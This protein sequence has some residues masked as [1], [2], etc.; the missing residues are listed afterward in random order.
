MS[1]LQSPVQHSGFCL[2]GFG[3]DELIGL[4]SSAPRRPRYFFS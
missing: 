3:L 1:T 4:A 2:T